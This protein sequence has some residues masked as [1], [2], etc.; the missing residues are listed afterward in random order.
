[1]YKLRAGKEKTSIQITDWVIH[2]RQK[3]HKSQFKLMSRLW[4]TMDGHVYIEK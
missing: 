1:M 4:T 2:F 3:E